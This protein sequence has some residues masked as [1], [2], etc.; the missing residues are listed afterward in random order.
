MRW[1]PGLLRVPQDLAKQ[2]GLGDCLPG[3]LR[4]PKHDEQRR[5]SR[6]P[7]A[8]V[9]LPVRMRWEPV[10]QG[11]GRLGGELDNPTLAPGH[12]KVHGHLAVSTPNDIPDRQRT[13]LAGTQA[14]VTQQ[15]YGGSV[16]D[17]DRRCQVGLKQQPL[18]LGG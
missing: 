1:D 3:G 8:S 15:P 16:T 12:L 13:H 18:V 9:R 11:T 14:N 6:Q 4:R 10:G 17:A 2:T 5:L 7:P